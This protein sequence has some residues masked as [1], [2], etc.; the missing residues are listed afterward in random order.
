MFCSPH[1]QKN[2]IYI[3]NLRAEVDHGIRVVEDGH[4]GIGAGVHEVLGE[5]LARGHVDVLDAAHAR[6]L[7]VGRRHEYQG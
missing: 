7:P 2:T 4:E 6:Y 5:A 3:Y 1:A